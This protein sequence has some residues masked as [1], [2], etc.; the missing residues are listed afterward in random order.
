MTSAQK[1]STPGAQQIE[2]DILYA[3]SHLVK[4]II[5]ALEKVEMFDIIHVVTRKHS[6]VG[7]K[8]DFPE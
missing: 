8:S 1:C 4:K 2:G 6:K 7:I 5:K 3:K